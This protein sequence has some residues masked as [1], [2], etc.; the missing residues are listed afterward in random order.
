MLEDSVE[1]AVR[2]YES[3][4]LTGPRQAGKTCM[5]EEV[6]RRLFPGM[7]TIA[8]DTPSDLDEFRRDPRLFFANHPGVLFLDEV[9]HA[10]DIFPYLKKEIDRARGTFRFFGV[11][12]K[13]AGLGH[14]GRTGSGPPGAGVG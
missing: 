10:P 12:Q 2:N 11:F 3:I 4:A 6:A 7:E 13:R 1:E 8:F 5:I 9:R 14:S